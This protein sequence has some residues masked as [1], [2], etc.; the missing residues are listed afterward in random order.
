MPTKLIGD[1]RR[2]ALF[3]YYNLMR[4]VER[5]VHEMSSL[6][7]TFVRRPR[8]FDEALQQVD[9]KKRYIAIRHEYDAASSRARTLAGSIGIDFKTVTF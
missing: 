9:V 6:K 3:E 5:Q 7:G 2:R 8:S 1:A 4:Q